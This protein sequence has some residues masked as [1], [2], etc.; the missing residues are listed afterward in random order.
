MQDVQTEH[1][2]NDLLSREG[3]EEEGRS[4]E[5]SGGAREGV[6]EEGRVQHLRLIFDE[7]ARL[8]E[9]LR[10]SERRVEEEMV[11]RRG[12]LDQLDYLRQ[13][14]LLQLQNT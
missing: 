5:R 2:E 4:E 9:E 6:E 1:L 8:A 12:I 7:E 14:K 10:E 3:S 13:M 11:R